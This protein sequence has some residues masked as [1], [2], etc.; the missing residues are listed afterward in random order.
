MNSDSDAKAQMQ[1]VN[2]AYEVLK[3]VGS[4]SRYDAGL[5]LQAAAGRPAPLPTR[6]NAWR[7]PYRCGLVLVT[8]VG[9]IGRLN[10]KRIL[11]WG[12]IVDAA[13]RILVTYWRYG[14][15]EYSERWV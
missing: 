9:E 4:R 12:D 7:P 6:S 15:D 2:E 13:G 1:R 14:D 5:K 8:G 11:Q 10:V 3:D